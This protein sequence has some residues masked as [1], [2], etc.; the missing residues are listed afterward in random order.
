MK[1]VIGTR[2]SELALVQAEL[3]KKALLAAEPTLSIETKIITT[4]GDVNQKPIPLDVNGK[5][6]FT[7]E[8]EEELLKGTIDIAVH[9]LKDVGDEMPPG[10]V[11][12]AYLPREDARDVLL[13]KNGETL[14]TLPLGAVVGTDS[15]RRKVQLL[16]IRSD[17]KVESVRGNVPTRITK[18]ETGTY[19]ALILA[20]AGL[21]RLSIEDRIVR[22]FEQSE[23]TS[24]PGQGIMAIQTRENEIE[25]LSL[26]A[27]V[28]DEEAARAA[29]TE[30]AFSHAVGGGCKSP[31]AAYASQN[32]DTMHL[33]GMTLDSK[34][35]IVRGEMNASVSES[36][37]L[38]EL[39]AKKLLAEGGYGKSS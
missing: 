25:L 11:L 32:G 13:T 22:Y 30:R 27:R 9:S 36:E 1:I 17:L 33:V 34:E 23:M 7:K 16:A 38:G 24:A 21:K 4:E 26:L 35:K 8:I 28:N 29:R 10:L 2:G 6:W 37:T 39:L 14:E 31:T 12:A 5:G 18:M 20:A 15:A 19:D 3:T